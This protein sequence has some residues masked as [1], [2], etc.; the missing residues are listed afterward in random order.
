MTADHAKIG[1]RAVLLLALASLTAASA[2]PRADVPSIMKPLPAAPAAPRPAIELRPVAHWAV[3]VPAELGLPVPDQPAD[4]QVGGQLG[5]LRPVL[6]G[7][8][9]HRDVP[10][11]RRAPLSR[12]RAGV[13]RERGR[14]APGRRP[15]LRTS[16]FR[17]G[18][19]GWASS[20]LR[21]GRRRGPALRELLLAVRDRA[22]GRHAGEPGGPRRPGVPRPLRPAA[23]VRRDPHLREVVRPGHRRVHLPGAHPHG[24][25][26]GTDRAAPVPGH[27]RPGPP[28]RGTSRWSATSTC[29]CPAATRACAAS[30]GAT[31]SSRPRTSGATSGAR[32]G[33]PGRT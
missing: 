25:A 29:T 15:A 20:S 8:L 5:P 6:L 28:R 26:L 23:G 21:A 32:P 12:P 10:G 30:C 17:D 22:A 9:L 19:R 16:Q 18:Y 2:P 1:R 27:H 33:G 3:G 13:R 14:L 4:E 7:R 31:R 11:H 24:G